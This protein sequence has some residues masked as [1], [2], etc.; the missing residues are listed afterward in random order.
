M[1][2]C[3]FFT[4]GWLFIL[5]VHFWFETGKSLKRNEN[6]W[7]F[8]TLKFNLKIN[9]KFP[10]YDSKILY[11]FFE[12]ICH[13]LLTWKLKFK[14]N[15]NQSDLNSIQIKFRIQIK[16]IRFKFKSNFKFKSLFMKLKLKNCCITSKNQMPQLK[17]IMLIN[18]YFNKKK[19]IK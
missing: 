5:N 17:I 7:E 19:L 14:F 10:V 3:W 15:L 9:Q 2:C 6:N 12:E 18:N 13:N 11:N 1:G 16:S 8:I 4:S